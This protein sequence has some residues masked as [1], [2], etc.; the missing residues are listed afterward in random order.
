VDRGRGVKN[1]IFCGRHKWMA[2]RGCPY[3]GRPQNERLG[4]PTGPCGRPQ[5]SSQLLVSLFQYILQRSLWVVMMK[6]Q[7]LFLNLHAWVGIN[8][9]V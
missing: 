1:V 2:L 3:K 8:T 9:K 4:R 6:Y 5:A 7:W